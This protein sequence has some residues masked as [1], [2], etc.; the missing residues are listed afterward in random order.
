M[1]FLAASL[2][3]VD[4]MPGCWLRQVCVTWMRSE[5]LENTSEV[6]AGRER[7]EEVERWREGG[8]GGRRKDEEGGTVRLHV[9][10]FLTCLVDSSWRS[11]F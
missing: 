8:D 10:S 11:S 4:C 2:I 5:R 9:S 6:E 7:G 3:S 1:R